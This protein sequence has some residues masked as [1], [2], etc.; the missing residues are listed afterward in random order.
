MKKHLKVIVGIAVSIFFLWLAFRKVDVHS[1]W[2]SMKSANP[3][4]LLTTMIMVILMLLIRGVRWRLLLE[5]VGNVKVGPLFWSTCI[6]FAINNVLPARLGEIARAY[7]ISRK[8]DVSMGSAFGTIVVERLWDSF[9]VLAMFAI[10]LASFTFPDIQ[11]A[12]GISQ[13][14]FLLNLAIFLIVALGGLFLLKWKTTF[15]LTLGE[16]SLFF[17]PGRWRNAV[18]SAVASFIRGLTMTRRPFGILMVAFWAV[19]LW[20]I[21]WL[22]VYIQMRACSI[23]ATG[24]G[25]FFVLMAMCLAVAIPA[26]PGY[27]G[28]YQFL[29]S[30][31]MKL[32]APVTPEQALSC[33]FVI[34]FCNVI[35]QTLPGLL[36][37]AREGISVKELET[38]KHEQEAASGE[39]P[40]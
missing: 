19:A 30:E 26:S 11:K 15:M 37:F 40:I 22:T 13:K 18:I 21:S 7:S 39:Q 8:S 34:W 35:P 16:K 14:T 2:N 5:P 20:L 23:P 24:T 4:L 10:A 31:A 32:V 28:T 38:A 27:I 6:G 1:L 33:A 17:L 12:F 29:A 36:A 25:S 9:S 3:W